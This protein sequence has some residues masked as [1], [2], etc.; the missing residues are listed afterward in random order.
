MSRIGV[1]FNVYPEEGKMDSVVRQIKEKM[2]PASIEAQDIAFGI[3][4]LK[5]FFVFEE[6]ETTSTKLEEGLKSISGVSQ[7]DVSEESL[8]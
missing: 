3:K 8:V 4:V 2:K 7:I 1:V 5:V 6:S